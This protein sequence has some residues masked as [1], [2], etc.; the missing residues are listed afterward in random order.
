MDH[1]HKSAVVHGLGMDERKWNDLIASN[2]LTNKLDST[3]VT[4]QKGAPSSSVTS[5]AANVAWAALKFAG[6]ALSFASRAHPAAKLASMVVQQVPTLM[7]EFADPVMIPAEGIE[8]ILYLD[9]SGSMSGNLALGKSALVSMA[10][11]LKG[12]KTRIV[13]FGAGKT[14]ISPREEK[15]S[16]A[17]TCLNWDGSS[18]STYMWKM[19][20]EDVLRRF[21]PGPPGASQGK[22]RLVVIT[23]GFDTDSPG[24]YCGIKG[25]DPMMKTLLAKGYDVEFHIVVLGTHYGHEAKAAL[26][27]YRSLAEATGGGYMALSGLYA[28]PKDPE[29]QSF[30]ANLEASNDVQ[31][32]RALR[33]KQRQGYLSDARAGRRENFEWLKSLPPS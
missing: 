31:K 3:V 29:M 2:A 20:E 33:A 14:V 21:R 9:D 6:P 16:T 17:L 30:M 23:D 1:E 32:S 24:A 18:G 11:L 27:R 12:S 15:W 5:M 26:G 22:L 8:T 4:V 10:H 28:S 25:M 19:I 7:D 13:K